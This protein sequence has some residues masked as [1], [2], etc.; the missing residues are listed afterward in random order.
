MMKRKCEG[1]NEHFGS[2]SDQSS[3]ANTYMY[4]YIYKPNQ[5]T[6][7]F[8]DNNIKQT[9]PNNIKTSHIQKAAFPNKDSKQ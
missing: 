4:I 9:H 3:Q 8:T 7:T 5:L 6:S 2:Y 1:V